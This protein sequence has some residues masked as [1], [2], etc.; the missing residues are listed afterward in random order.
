MAGN[1]QTQGEINQVETRTIQRVSTKREAV[2][3]RKS[4]R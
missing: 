2:S 4:T 1:N 3:L